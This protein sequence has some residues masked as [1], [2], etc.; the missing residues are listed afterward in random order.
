M[1]G[2]PEADEPRIIVDEDWKSQVQAEKVQLERDR[3]SG[4][5]AAATAPP[6]A[7]SPADPL[8]VEQP[9][10]ASLPALISLVVA[11]IFGDLDPPSAGRPPGPPD[12]V[13]ARF[14]IDLL[15]VLEDKTRGNRTPAEDQLL[16]GVL[17]EVRLA[18]VAAKQGA[19]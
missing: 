10:P 12:L 16:A 2:A 1:T 9:P 18:Y 3:Q 13:G 8:R 11:Q 4:S 5:A 19:T 17:H 6:K 15:Q 14:F 7:E